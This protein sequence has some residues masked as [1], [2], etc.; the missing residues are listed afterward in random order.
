MPP[1]GSIFMDWQQADSERRLLIDEDFSWSEPP[2]PSRRRAT[3]EPIRARRRR[4][5]GSAAARAERESVM[6]REPAGVHESWN[7]PTSAHSHFDEM[8]REWNAAY[9]DAPAYAE[10]SAPIPVREHA[11]PVREHAAPVRVREAPAGNVAVLEP[12]VVEQVLEP[13]ARE[14]WEAPVPDARERTFDLSD[15]GT[16]GS[17]HRRTVVISGRGDDRYMP[18]PRRRHPSEDLRFHERSTFSPD[19]AGLWALLLGL[20]LLVGAIVH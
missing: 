10:V 5:A 9:G 1:T 17:P 6:Q 8:M 12:P 3:E 11:A 4:G 16:G 14:A 7:Q 20:A 15:P 19:R 13:P 18:A 2:A